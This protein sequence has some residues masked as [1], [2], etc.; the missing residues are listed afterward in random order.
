MKWLRDWLIDPTVKAHDVDSPEFSMAHRKI[1]QRKPILRQLFESFYRDCRTM[2]LRHFDDCPGRRLEIGSGAGIISDVYPDVITSDIKVLPFIDIV[3]SADK[4]PFDDNSLRAIYAVN[5]FHH[6]PSPRAF[7]AEAL[8]VLHPGGGVV[9]IEPFYGP[10]AS[11][12][13]KNLH[14]SEGFEPDDPSWEAS[15][16]TGPFSNA[17]Q[18]LSY[19]VFKRDRRT[20]EKEFP[21]LEIVGERPHTHVWYV[22]SGGVNFRQL[23][24]NE[25][26][27]LAK[28]AE[29]TLAPFNRW[30]ALQQTIVLRKKIGTPQLAK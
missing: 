6:L 2:D 27:W 16:N 11:W 20:F 26:T 21:G 29:G 13:F 9:L 30:I 24:P 10:V 25:L 18:A 12:M 15:G 1:V 23:V 28:L 8:R 7:F 19:I 17:N 14:K 22:V 5:V 3:L 4:L